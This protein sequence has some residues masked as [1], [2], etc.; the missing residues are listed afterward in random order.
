[1]NLVNIMMCMSALNSVVRTSVGL[2]SIKLTEDA[3]WLSDGPEAAR[4]FFVFFLGLVR[5]TTT[6]CTN[7]DAYASSNCA[8]P[9]QRKRAARR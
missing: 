5:T 2:V 1:M 3:G 9:Y 4:I 8:L 6:Y 7:D